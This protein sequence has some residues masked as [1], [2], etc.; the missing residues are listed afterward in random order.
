MERFVAL[1]CLRFHFQTIILNELNP[2]PGQIVG[3]SSTEFGLSNMIWAAVVVGKVSRTI[4][5][6]NRVESDGTVLTL[7]P[8]ITLLGTE[9]QLRNNPGK[10]T[11]FRGAGDQR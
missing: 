6:T 5:A 3:L 2:N 9:R 4:I 7:V 8:T 1:G 11:L 10:C